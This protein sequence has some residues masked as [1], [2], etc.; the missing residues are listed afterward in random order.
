[1]SPLQSAWLLL[2]VSVLAEVLGSVG[3]KYSAG[4]SRPLPSVLT[5]VCYAC[6]VWLMALATKRLEMGLAYASWAAASTAATAVIGI[7][8]FDEAVS[9]LKLAGIA[10]TV[11]A[12]V[13]LNLGE[14]ATH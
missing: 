5:V 8:C 4:F 2:G 11:C 3:L 7:V 13:A 12:L 10:L 6:A 14:A 1:M 9:S